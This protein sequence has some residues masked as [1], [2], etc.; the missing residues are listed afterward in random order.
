[1]GT[2]VFYPDTP[3]GTF[4][5]AK[6]ASTL[7]Y[8]MVTDRLAA[9]VENISTVE[10]SGVK[11]HVPVQL[12]F[13]PRPAAPKTLHRRL[14]PKLED[15]RVYGPLPPPPTWAVPLGLAEAALAAAR[16][17]SARVDDAM[18]KAYAAW[19]NMAEEELEGITGA[20]VKKRGLRSARPKLVW[21]SVLPEKNMRPAFSL[22]AAAVW[23]RGIAG[24]LQ[25]IIAIAQTVND[26]ACTSDDQGTLHTETFDDEDC[27]DDM[28]IS[29]DYVTS[30]LDDGNAA[31]D[32]EHE[33]DEEDGSLRA[34]WD[35]CLQVMNDILW[36]TEY[37]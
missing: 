21:R 23:L 36:S 16:A 3:R 5:T 20:P 22:P 27:D 35:R 11:G 32:V 33:G 34:S 10:G 17:G 30:C 19:A 1:M 12:R 13:K 25:R 4:R 37:D 28:G 29:D 31:A 8:F 2:T 6:A 7:D 24:E 15:E 9:A 26:G 14:P 18:E